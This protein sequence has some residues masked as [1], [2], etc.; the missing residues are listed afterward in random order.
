[1]KVYRIERKEDGA[2]VYHS[3]F[4]LRHISHSGQPSPWEDIGVYPTGSHYYGFASLEQMN[5]WFFDPDWYDECSDKCIV[6]IYEADPNY[7]LLGRHQIAFIKATS[8]LVNEISLKDVAPKGMTDLQK[9]QKEQRRLWLLEQE[10]EERKWQEKIV[11]MSN[12]GP[13]LIDL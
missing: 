1:M 6:R 10:E 8:H 2:G 7:I 13:Q 12:E 11:I 9:A 4:A 3:G 5:E